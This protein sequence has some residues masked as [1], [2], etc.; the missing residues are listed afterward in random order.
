MSDASDFHHW[1]HLHRVVIPHRVRVPANGFLLV[2]KKNSLDN[3]LGRCRHFEVYRIAF[4]EVDRSTPQPARKAE[5][6]VPERHAGSRSHVERRVALAGKRDFKRLAHLHRLRQVKTDVA[7]RRVPECKNQ[8]LL[9]LTFL[10]IG[11]PGRM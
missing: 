10:G 3:E 6:V 7:R 11:T 4:D 8:Q 2:G 1:K 5:F 9:G